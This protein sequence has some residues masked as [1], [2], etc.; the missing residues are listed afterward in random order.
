VSA[1]FLTSPSNSLRQGVAFRVQ[2]SNNYWRAGRTGLHRVESGSWVATYNYS[3]TFQDGDRITVAFSGSNI[4]VNRNG[5]Q[6]LSMTHT[7][8]QTATQVGLVVT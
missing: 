8:F 1:T 2:D 6:V 3:Q 5:T 7:T 4:A